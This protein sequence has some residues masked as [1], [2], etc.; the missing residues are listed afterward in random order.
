VEKV[1]N[2]KKVC[3]TSPFNQTYPGSA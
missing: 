2:I 1:K 3:V